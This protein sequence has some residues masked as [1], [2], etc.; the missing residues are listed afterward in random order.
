MMINRGLHFTARLILLTSIFIVRCKRNH[1][2]S[3]SSYNI[4]AHSEDSYHLESK[5]HKRN[6]NPPILY[7][8]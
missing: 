8:L 5:Y 2:M 1:E 7:H 4:D 3:D 6:I